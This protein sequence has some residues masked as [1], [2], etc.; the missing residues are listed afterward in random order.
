MFA[1]CVATDPAELSPEPIS[2]EAEN[3]AGDN[4]TENEF[5]NEENYV[6]NATPEQT[7]TTA[8]DIK[9]QM[10]GNWEWYES[11]SR[12]CRTCQFICG[13]QLGEASQF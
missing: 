5:P 9:A 8:D 6:E 4:S 2:L 10:A 1:A 13:W 7:E 3:S 11:K 12:T